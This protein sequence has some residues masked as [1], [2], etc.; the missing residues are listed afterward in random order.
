MRFVLRRNRAVFLE[1][2]I[3]NTMFGGL[4]A[5]LLGA[6]PA[7][8]G[9]I[10]LA[11]I[12]SLPATHVRQQ[13][14]AWTAGWI[15]EEE[16]GRQ[17]IGTNGVEGQHLAMQPFQL[18]AGRHLA[19]GQPR[20]GRRR[21][22]RRGHGRRPGARILLSGLDRVEPEQYPTILSKQVDQYISHRGHRRDERNDENRCDDFPGA[23]I[24]HPSQ[25]ADTC[26]TVR[27]RPSIRS[28]EQ[29]EEC[30]RAE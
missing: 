10:E 1:Q 22:G 28:E 13:R 18:E 20:G 27:K 21:P 6:S 15:G 2:D 9:D 24:T 8:D 19:D 29:N 11:G 14:V 17:T 12:V 4:R 5:I 16:H 3:R 25:Q 30:D 7:D 23:Q 26:I